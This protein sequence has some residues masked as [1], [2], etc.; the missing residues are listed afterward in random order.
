MES[1]LTL[2]DYVFAVHITHSEY[3]ADEWGTILDVLPEHVRVLNI[4][5]SPLSDRAAAVIMERGLGELQLY[6][7]YAN[8]CMSQEAMSRAPYNMWC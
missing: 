4:N 1:I 5:H 7:V 2:P 8:G 6:R 3:D